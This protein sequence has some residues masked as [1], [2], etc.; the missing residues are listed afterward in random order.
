MGGRWGR[1]DDPEIREYNRLEE[2]LRSCIQRG[3]S[4][5]TQTQIHTAEGLL[6]MPD[7]GFRYELLRG[8]L[9]KM[10][11]SGHKHGKI[12]VRFGWR[13]AQYV[14]TKGL[15][16]VYAAETGFLLSSNPDTV[17]APDVAFVSQERVEDVGDVEGYWPGAPD[18]AVEVI[19]PGDTYSEVEEKAV[20]WLQAG[21]RLVVVVDP[22]K[23]SVTVY[24]GL[25]N[26]T[27]LTEGAT[28]E[29]GDVAPGWILSI[30]DLFV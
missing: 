8:E 30:Q 13:L 6:K 28:L 1:V 20:E 5:T 29:G 4:M 26:I 9:K 19:S 7:D 18:M 12:A 22:R 23:R 15:G 14:E 16:V 27:I 25:D 2:L 3:P 17:L 10:S 11:P 21:A 24:R